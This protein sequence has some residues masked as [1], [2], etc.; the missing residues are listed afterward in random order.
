MKSRTLLRFYPRAWRERYGE[1]VA[2]LVDEMGMSRIAAFDLFVGA[3][4]EWVRFAARKF[5]GRNAN[6][7]P[8]PA[9]MCP[10]CKT[11]IGFDDWLQM[12]MRSSAVNGRL[13][14]ECASCGA[15]N[16]LTPSWSVAQVLSSVALLIT[17]FTG[18]IG[19]G[20]SGAFFWVKAA[21]YV[22]ACTAWLVA[23]RVVRLETVPVDYGERR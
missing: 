20:V 4:R 22:V 14:R 16:R 12:R 10:S 7:L 11:S 13:I 17:M 15:L 2:A 5:T 23:S 21:F 8:T 3:G 9:M 6:R 1:E 18:L 19:V